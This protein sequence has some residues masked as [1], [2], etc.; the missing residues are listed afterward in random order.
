MGSALATT[1]IG[2]LIPVLSDSGELATPFTTDLVAA[3]AV[4]EFS[5]ILL[6]TIVLSTPNSLR[7]TLILLTFGQHIDQWSPMRQ[8]ARRRSG[9]PVC[10]R[11]EEPL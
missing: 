10:H 5:P 4:E 1:A 2:I 9:E 7:N 8:I 11:A 6:L 3:G